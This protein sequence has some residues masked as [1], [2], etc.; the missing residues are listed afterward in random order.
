MY[1]VYATIHVEDNSMIGI[2]MFI[3]K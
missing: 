1:K 2:V 3:I